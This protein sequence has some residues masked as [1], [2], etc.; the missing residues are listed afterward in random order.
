MMAPEAPLRWICRRSAGGHLERLAR[1]R[2][3]VRTPRQAAVHVFAGS[4][5][6]SC[7]FARIGRDILNRQSDAHWGTRHWITWL[8]TFAA[9]SEMRGLSSRSLRNKTAFRRGLSRA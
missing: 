1:R 5:I 7:A 6:A 4:S 2:A 8:P 9:T 3:K